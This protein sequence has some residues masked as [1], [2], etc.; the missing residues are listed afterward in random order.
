MEAGIQSSIARII[1]TNM[2]VALANTENNFD[3]LPPDF[4]QFEA[5]FALVTFIQVSDLI[6]IN[7]C[8]HFWKW[9]TYT[10]CQNQIFKVL[11]LSKTKHILIYVYA[12]DSI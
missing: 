9:S 11:K 7:F 1:A 4:S 8:N 6:H 12:R 10:Y 5:T 3:F 2:L